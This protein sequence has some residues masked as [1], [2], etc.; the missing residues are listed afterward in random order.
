MRTLYMTF[1]AS[2]LIGGCAHTRTYPICFYDVNIGAVSSARVEWPN[3]KARYEK[4][5]TSITGDNKNWA[6]LSS[7]I[8]V[9]NAR[10]YT[11]DE[12]SH[13]WPSIACYGESGGAESMRLRRACEIYIENSLASQAKPDLVSESNIP[14]C[15][16]F[17][18]L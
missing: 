13:I 4:I 7:R 15:Q 12:I 14:V 2:F 17:T 5:L 11:H 18:D 9:V 10:Y 1:F 3:L 6:V 8:A 16:T